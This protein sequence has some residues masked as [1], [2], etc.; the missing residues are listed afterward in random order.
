MLARV[1]C[2]GEQLC[3]PLRDEARLCSVLQLILRGVVV[4]ESCAEQ[5]LQQCLEVSAMLLSEMDMAFALVLEFH[6]KV[7]LNCSLWSRAQPAVVQ[8]WL[9]CLVPLVQT[10]AKCARFVIGVQSMLDELVKRLMKP[11]ILT[12][13]ALPL[14]L[15]QTSVVVIEAMVT[16]SGQPL[17]MAEY[18]AVINFAHQC[19]SDE[20]MADILLMLLRLISQ[21]HVPANAA[22]DLSSPAK[23]ISHQASYHNLSSDDILVIA[24]NM[25]RR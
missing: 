24:T 10:H 8:R 22:G 9:D 15:A 23:E 20:L 19:Q 4:V 5:L 12:G 2:G 6:I 14:K 18:R 11:H 16:H 13:E 7:V 1:W 17:T 25:C 21:W 3:A